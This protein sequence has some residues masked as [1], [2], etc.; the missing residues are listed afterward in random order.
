MLIWYSLI[1][2]D[3]ENSFECFDFKRRIYKMH[4]HVLW[5]N[6]LQVDRTMVGACTY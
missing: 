5:L 4:A 3:F 2:R 6:H 1:S